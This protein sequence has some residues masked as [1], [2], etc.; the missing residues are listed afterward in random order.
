MGN[1]ADLVV[2][3]LSIWRRR[4]RAV[5]VPLFTAFAPPVIAMRLEGLEGQRDVGRPRGRAVY[6]LCPRQ[7]RPQPH[8][9]RLPAGPSHAAAAHRDPGGGLCGRHG[10]RRPS[11]P[12][13]PATEH[14]LPLM[15]FVELVTRPV[16]EPETSCTLCVVTGRNPSPS[17]AGQAFIDLLRRHCDSRSAYEDRDRTPAASGAPLQ[18]PDR[19]GDRSPEGSCAGDRRRP[20]TH[21]L[22]TQYPRPEPSSAKSFNASVRR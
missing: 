15:S 13:M 8:R 2:A 16:S 10:R 6:R 20:G 3:L 9:Y 5:H 22:R 12:T 7:Q 18:L 19:G 21:S 14:V 11:A 1:S 17:P 4:R